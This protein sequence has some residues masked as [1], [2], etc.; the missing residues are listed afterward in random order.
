VVIQNNVQYVIPGKEAR[1]GILQHICFPVMYDFLS[2]M[3]FYKCLTSSCTTQ[4][5]DIDEDAGLQSVINTIHIK[6]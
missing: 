2:K 5:V 3:I 4:L 1:T 6:R